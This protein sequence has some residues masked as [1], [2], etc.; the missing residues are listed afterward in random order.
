MLDGERHLQ[1]VE[2]LE[3]AYALVEGDPLE[4]SRINRMIGEV[5]LDAGSF[6]LAAKHLKGAID[7]FLREQKH[8]IV[9]LSAH[10][11]Q[12]YDEGRVAIARGQLDEAQSKTLEYRT[13]LGKRTEY[14][15]KDR[16]GELAARLALANGSPRLAGRQLSQVSDTDPRIIFLKGQILETVGAMEHA[17]EAYETVVRYNE[18][19]FELAFVRLKAQRRLAEL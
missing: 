5:Y 7:D 15:A 8:Q 2:R 1:A 13:S 3:Q 9:R 10:S 16:Y 12:I 11:E 14:T 18:P 6:D 4:A 17:R 19:R